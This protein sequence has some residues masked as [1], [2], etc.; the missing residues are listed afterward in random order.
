MALILI[1][2]ASAFIAATISGIF[3]MAGG[4]LLLGCMLATGMSPLLAIPIHG[5]VQLV[6]N[7]T[8]T[9]AYLKSV[10]W[11][12]F[13]LFA[14]FSL[15][16]P[17]LASYF[18]GSVD[19]NMIKIFIACAI[20]YATWAPK[21]SLRNIPDEIAFSIAGFIAGFLGILIGAVGPTIAPFFIRKGFHKERIIATKA[22]CQG[23]IHITKIITFGLIGFNFTEQSHIILPM[24]VCVIF[25]TFFGKYLVKKI[26][27]ENYL[28]YYKFLLTGLAVFL[29][30]NTQI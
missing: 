16:G 2:S 25:G 26:S 7:L 24:I 29:I 5:A 21:W 17:I 6:S 4:A 27:E 15:P 9:L 20:I 14:F 22:I 28:I 30:I 3:G 19:A 11:Q 18:I 1:L 10:Y 12:V 23:F 8:R 13:I